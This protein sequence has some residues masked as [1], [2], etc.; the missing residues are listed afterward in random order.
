M[1][2]EIAVLEEELSKVWAVKAG[3]MSALLTGRVR[4]V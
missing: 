2:A 3:M 1:V 4:L